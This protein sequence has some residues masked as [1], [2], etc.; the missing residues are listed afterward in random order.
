LTNENYSKVLI[1]SMAMLILR[2]I[3]SHNHLSQ[4]GAIAMR[5]SKVEKNK[6]QVKLVFGETPEPTFSL[7]RIMEELGLELH[8][9]ATQAG[10]LIMKALMDAEEKYLAGERDSRGTDINR[11]GSQ[12]GSV[13]VGGQKVQ[14]KRTR[15]R[16]GGKKEVRLESYDRFTKNDSRSYGVYCRMLAGVS[17][18]DYQKTVESVRDGYGISKSVV[19]REVVQATAKDLALLCER[20][21]SSLDIWVLVIDGV[22]VGGTTQIVALGVDYSGKKRFLGFREGSTENTRVCLDLL[23]DLQRRGLSADHPI[24]VVIDGSVALRSAVEKFFGDKVYV[25]RCQ[26]H[27]RQN[28]KSYLPKE[29]HREYDRKIAAAYAMNNYE[30]AR[31]ALEVVV[32]D[33]YRINHKA[34]GSLEEGFEETL[35][36]HRLNIP[37]VLRKSFSTTNLIESPFSHTRKVLRN[38]KRWRS[39]SNQAQRWTATALLEAE[40][41]FRAVKGYRSMSVLKSAL[42]GEQM[43]QSAEKQYNA[44]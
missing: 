14:F 26:H 20:D 36:L 21:L 31:R 42:E 5:E 44:A 12:Q 8:S 13:M 30:D 15:L 39:N 3:I 22:E 23:H 27:K 17:C 35:T 43:K 18:R 6:A 32:M 4:K 41:R 28:V 10:F 38:V 37:P 24:I 19:G 9:F 33:L 7:E 29:Y 1:K 34:G 16:H 2:R 11:W 40:K 25:Q